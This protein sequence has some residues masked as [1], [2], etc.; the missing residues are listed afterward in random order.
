MSA[1]Y[2][3]GK[4]V[5]AISEELDRFDQANVDK[6]RS[7]VARGDD[8]G[9]LFFAKL[10]C[11]NGISIATVLKALEGLNFTSSASK[12]RGAIARDLNGMC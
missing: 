3:S 2:L 5:L 1:E 12:I 9:S 11:K 10:C 4:E 8:I 7:E 6:L